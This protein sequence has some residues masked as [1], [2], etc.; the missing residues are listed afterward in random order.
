[1]KSHTYKVSPGLA[2][3]SQLGKVPSGER[4][5]K[6]GREGFLLFYRKNVSMIR[7][8]KKRKGEL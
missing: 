2:K 6:K 1:M 7:G 4:R 3:I 5:R 8:E